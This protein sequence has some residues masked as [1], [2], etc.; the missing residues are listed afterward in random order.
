MKGKGNVKK[1]G[2]SAGLSGIIGRHHVIFVFV[3]RVSFAAE[4]SAFGAGEHGLLVVPTQT[5][6]RKSGVFTCRKE[7]WS[8]V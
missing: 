6:E 8:D 7:R 5:P 1:F 3:V 2:R 4:V